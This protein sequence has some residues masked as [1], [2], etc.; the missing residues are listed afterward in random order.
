MK[1]DEKLFFTLCFAFTE[2]KIFTPRDIV[3]MVEGVIHY[4]R[5]WYL[6]RKWCEKGFYDYGT[7]LDLGWFYPDKVPEV[8]FERSKKLLGIVSP[9]TDI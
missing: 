4:K 7:T 2:S 3:Y 9:T 8:Y 1:D 5:C 6:L